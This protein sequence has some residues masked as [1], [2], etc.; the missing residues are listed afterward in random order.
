MNNV[1][2]DIAVTSAATGVAV[3]LI[4]EDPILGIIYAAGTALG[5]GTAYDAAVEEIALME[6]E[7][8]RRARSIPVSAV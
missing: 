6:A 3:G 5:M 8:A 1:Q 4:T 2:R 7:E